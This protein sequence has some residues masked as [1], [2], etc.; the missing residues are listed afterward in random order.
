[1]IESLE[2]EDGGKTYACRIDDAPGARLTGW[3]WFT[4]SGDGHKYAP[5]RAEPGD[6]AASVKSRIVAYY[7]NHQERRANPTVGRPGWGRRPGATPAADAAPAP[8]VEARPAPPA[9]KRKGDSASQA[10][11]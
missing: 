5:F 10:A 9:A 4:V 7:T 1:V 3:W 6:T 2:F 11:S 8:E